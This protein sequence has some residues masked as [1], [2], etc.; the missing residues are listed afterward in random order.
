MNCCRCQDQN[1][2]CNNDF[3][4]PAPLTAKTAVS[5]IEIRVSLLII[6]IQISGCF[7]QAVDEGLVCSA[8][9]GGNTNSLDCTL[10]GSCDEV[11][12]NI[13]LFS[14][15]FLR[16]S[17]SVM[18]EEY[19]RSL[20]DKVLGVLRVRWTKTTIVR[21]TLLSRLSAATLCLE[22]CCRPDWAC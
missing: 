21:I 4:K 11:S 17:R 13:R 12:L 18:L 6:R 7:F 9:T 8:T 16:R 19:L 22:T 2:F 5:V 1:A 14:A 10:F 15:S 3:A 20:P